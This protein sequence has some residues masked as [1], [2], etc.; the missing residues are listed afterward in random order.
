MPTT[1]EVEIRLADNQVS[2]T[3]K[4]NPYR[5]KLLQ[6]LL[7]NNKD[8]NPTLVVSG[9]TVQASLSTMPFHRLTKQLTIIQ[10]S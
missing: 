8:R 10:T 5:L 3:A 1:F 9:I 7:K 4:L 2:L 6:L